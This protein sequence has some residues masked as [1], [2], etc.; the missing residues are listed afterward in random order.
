MFNRRWVDWVRALYVL[1]STES[2]FL[3]RIYDRQPQKP[4]PTAVVLNESVPPSGLATR[5][6][7]TEHHLESSQGGEK[8]IATEAPIPFKE[9]SSND[10]APASV[11]ICIQ[12]PKILS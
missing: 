2:R 1:R 7:T 5:D 10:P 11:F 6:V 9:K 4:R 12:Y 8:S 3:P